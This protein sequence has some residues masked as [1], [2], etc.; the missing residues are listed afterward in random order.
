[1]LAKALLDYIY[2]GEVE[3]MKEELEDFIKMAIG[4]QV[5][6]IL[7]YKD[8]LAAREEDTNEWGQ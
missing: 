2:G 4:L 5:R 7:D 8:S 6:G 1:M 3:L